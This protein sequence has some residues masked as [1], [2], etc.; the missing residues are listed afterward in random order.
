MDIRNFVIIAHIDHGKST[1][2]DR[3]LELTKSIDKRKM[4]EQ[5]LDQ[6]DL[7]RE[8]GIT[9]KMQPVTMKYEVND[10]EH[11]LNLI[12]TPGHVDFS[13]EVS[14]SLAAVEGAVLLVDASKG[15]QA[16]T[17]AHLTTAVEQG[18]K[19]IPAINKIDLPGAQIEETENEILELLISLDSDAERIHKIS[20]KTG[21]GIEELLADVVKTVPAPRID[22]KKPLRALIFDSVYDDYQGVITHVRVLEGEISPGTDIFFMGSKEKSESKEVGIFSPQRVKRKKLQAGDIGYIVGGIKEIEK[23]NIGDTITT[24]KNKATEPVAGYRQPQPVV[25]STIFTK[26]DSAFEDL[27][28]ALNKLKLNDA[29]LYFEP[30]SSPVLGRGFKSGFLGMLHMEIILERLR[31]EYDLDLLVTSPSVAYRVYLKSGEEETIFS[32]S[33]FPDPSEI[34]KTE[35]PWAHLRVITP[36]EYMNNVMKLLKT[37]RGEYADTEY[38]G[39]E[40]MRINYEVPLADIISD[41]YDN[42]KN[43]TSG[44]GSMFYE[45]A[46]YREEDIVK[47]DILLAGDEIPALS[48]LVPREKAQSEGRKVAE[49]IKEVLPPEQFAVAIQ[50]AIGGKVIARETKS[51]MRKDVTA[52][53]YGGDYSRKRKQLEKQKKGKKRLKEQGNVELDS[54]TLMKIFQ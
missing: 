38:I 44:Y 16:Q 6:M 47:M 39:K 33:Q 45:I 17:V 35:E 13:Y 51:A 36:P 42:L 10:K 49:K 32:P 27:R 8:R 31:R 23:A 46:E 3:F 5:F 15:I 30:E 28:D 18:L 11:I 50:A 29:S 24:V 48:R 14:R 9:I 19:I 2:A 22:I 37:I 34:E 26:E 43:T 12:D 1:L 20:A 54:E 41:F 7:E 52:G 40:R 53:L 21:E 4:Q 25:F